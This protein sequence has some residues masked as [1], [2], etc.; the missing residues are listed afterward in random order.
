[1]NSNLMDCFAN[2]VMCKLFLD[3]CQR[4]TVTAKQ[5]AE[6]YPDVA[7]TTLYRCLKRMTSDGLIKV[8]GENPV[9]GTVEKTYS[10]AVN[11]EES[12]ADIIANNDGDAYMLLFMQYISGFVTA[13]QTYSRRKDIDLQKDMAAFTT[14]PIFATDDELI[15]AL[16]KIGEVITGLFENNPSKERK[17]RNLG[18]IIT[19][20]LNIEKEK[21]Y[22]SSNRK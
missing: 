18:L 22:E 17:P 14:A 1:M 16:T 20:P 15:A 13:F 19:P 8:V 7:Q 21:H 2:P 12:I 5:L 10:I 3:I 4:E 6:T 9:R 11:V